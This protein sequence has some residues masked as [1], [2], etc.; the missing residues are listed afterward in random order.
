MEKT[1]EPK[2]GLKGVAAGQIQDKAGVQMNNDMNYDPL[3]KIE[4]HEL[5]LI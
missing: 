5:T 1:Q 4:I 3:T 2:R